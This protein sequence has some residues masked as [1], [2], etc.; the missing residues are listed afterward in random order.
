VV[1]RAAVACFA[2][3]LSACEVQAEVAVHATPQGTGRIEVSV[4]LDKAA[5][6]R[7]AGTSPVT[8]DLSAAG[9]EVDEPEAL[10][11]GGRRYRAEK[12]FR[13]PEEA[14]RILLEVGGEGGPLQGFR[15]RRERTFL[16]TRTRLEGVIDLREGAAA[17]GDAR[18]TELLGGQPLGV[19]PERAEALDDALHLRVSAHLP[20]RTTSASAEAGQ[21][22]P[23]HAVAERWNIASIVFAVL[24][25]LALVAFAVST[26]RALRARR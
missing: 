19:E 15:L 9:W 17:F 18:L 5:V 2:V 23:V 4:V 16:R 3:L 13:T 8:T 22:T 20:G 25:V 21:R 14:A 26:R 12:R 6:A 10:D 1:R 11:G 24:A 7:A